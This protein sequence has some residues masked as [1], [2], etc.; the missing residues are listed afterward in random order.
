MGNELQ[1]NILGTGFTGNGFEI[2][3]NPYINLDDSFVRERCDRFSM[4]LA[5]LCTTIASDKI[6]LIKTTKLLRV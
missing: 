1:G 6:H 2:S 4:A 3:R 5:S